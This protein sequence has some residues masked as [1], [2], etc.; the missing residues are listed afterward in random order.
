[1]NNLITIN[2]TTQ[3][4]YRDWGK[5]R[6]IV[7]LAGWGFNSD[8]WCNVMLA[9][10]QKGYRCIAFDRRGHGNSSDPG[11]GYDYDTLASD[12]NNVIETLQLEDAILVGSSMGCGEITRYLSRHDSGRVKGAVFV[13]TA[14]PLIRKSED[15]PNGWDDTILEQISNDIASSLPAWLEKNI[16]PFF[17][18]ST[19]QSVKDW[20]VRIILHSSLQAHVACLATMTKADFCKEL[21]A[22]K[23]PL[24]IVH[25]DKDVSHSLE[26]SGQKTAELVPNSQLK[27]YEGAPNGLFLT[28]MEQLVDD[29]GTFAANV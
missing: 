25:G 17:S 18:P 13:G 2:N 29:I 4:F 15:N 26:S 20:A 12:L 6:P 10:C 14:T 9:L 11:E 16:D 22:F 8:V 19:P 24:L 7:F 28:H 27:V 5:G 3:L 1:M 23:V 21:A